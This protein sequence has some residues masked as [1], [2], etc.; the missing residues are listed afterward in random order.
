MGRGIQAER[1]ADA[2]AL[3]IDFAWHDLR[4]ARRPGGL[5]QSDKAGAGSQ[6]SW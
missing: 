3:R 2:K 5:E 6:R 4:I 1:M